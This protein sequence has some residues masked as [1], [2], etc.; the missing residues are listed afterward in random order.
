MDIILSYKALER[1]T[2][3]L[4][5]EVIGEKIVIFLTTSATE[6]FMHV[7]G[8]KIILIRRDLQTTNLVL[9]NNTYKYRIAI[10]NI[11]DNMKKNLLTWSVVILICTIV[12]SSVLPS[13]VATDNQQNGIKIK[14]GDGLY[15]GKVTSSPYTG[16]LRVYV[17]EPVSR[18]NMQRGGPYHFGFLGF[19]FND[20]ISIDPQAT[21]QK[22]VTWNGDVTDTNVMVIAVV[23][24]SKQ[25]QAYSNAPAGNPFWAYYTDAAAA[26]TPGHTGYN[27]VATNFTHTV[28]I[29]EATATWCPYCPLMAEALYNISQLGIYP[30]YYVAM[31][32]DMNTQASSRV[33]NEYNI[34]GFP[35]GYYDGGYRVVVGGTTSQ[36]AYLSPLKSCGKHKVTALNLSVSL[37]Y[38]GSGNLQIGVN[39][40][41]NNLP[42]ATPQVPSGQINGTIGIKYNFTST[43]TDPN[44]D[45]ISYWFDWSDGTNSGWI[46]PYHPGVM[47]KA[48]HTW[49]K[50]GSY[51]IKV[52]A[53]DSSN[54]ESNWSDS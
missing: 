33:R 38:I 34:Y 27:R 29:E 17:V 45:D 20:N 16:R 46:G 3:N 24:N 15:T 47:A 21:L 42:P 4:Q 11:G 28:F 39:I 18:W 8:I 44:N 19:A 6:I 50:K 48:S 23:F 51:S 35:T 49:T 22:S 43:T 9:N 1:L 37:T 31:V 12:G 36:S 40:T 2:N 52:K 41:N 13:I 30:F 7:K 14:I 53:M 10:I 5:D 25:N 32:D 26:A 54:C